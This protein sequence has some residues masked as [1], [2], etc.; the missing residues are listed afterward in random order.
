M[1]KK[2]TVE[3]KAIPEEVAALITKSA[4]IRALAAMDWS[5]GEIAS[6]L[7]IRYQ[8]VRNVLVTPLK[9]QA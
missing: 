8:H 5:R 9:K 3:V 6:A 1:S 4:K 7:Q 2:A